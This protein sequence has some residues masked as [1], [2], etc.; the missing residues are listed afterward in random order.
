[1]GYGIWELHN[2]KLKGKNAAA[3]LQGLYKSTK[4]RQWLCRQGGSELRINP[5]PIA[6]AG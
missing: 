3:A 2:D 4:I 5:C 1:M 6:A